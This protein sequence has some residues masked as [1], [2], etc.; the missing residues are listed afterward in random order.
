MDRSCKLEAMLR[1]LS[2]RRKALREEQK[3]I[4]NRFIALMNELQVSLMSDEDLTVI[5]ADTFHKN[6]END[7]SAASISLRSR[8]FNSA[9]DLSNHEV[10]AS[11]TYDDHTPLKPRFTERPM[12]PPGDSSRGLFFCNGSDVL[13][14][15]LPLSSARTQPPAL[16]SAT[17]S[18][19]IAHEF[20]NSQNN[21]QANN[22][23]PTSTPNAR[24]PPQSHVENTPTRIL[25]SVSHPSPSA[26]R[27]G[28]RAW[29]EMHGHPPSE[30]VDFRTGMSGHSAI[31]SS[32][33][34][35]HQYLAQTRA[36]WTGMSN[37]TGL[38]MWK[39]STKKPPASIQQ[40]NLPAFPTS[41]SGDRND[42]YSVG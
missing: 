19:A 36:L 42:A 27:A 9:L 30:G 25:T 13:N 41:G 39:P 21:H 22:G 32:S 3:R 6:S 31:F 20:N 26:L 24:T 38:S 23:S 15:V 4:D 12:T 14:A 28:A 2:A 37:H 8:D 11:N 40:P 1:Q 5:A 17:R 18:P 34:H 10:K 35:S 33:A 29:R 7:P 16:P